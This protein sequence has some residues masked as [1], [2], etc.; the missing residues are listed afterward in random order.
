MEKPKYYL[1]DASKKPLGRIA[2]RAAFLL[3]GKNR[4]EFQPNVVAKHIIIIINAGK[5]YLSGTKNDSKQ[6]Y[7]YSGY[8]GGLKT[9]TFSELK[10]ENPVKIISHAVEG[11][12]PKNRLKSILIKN[13]KIVLTENHPY[14]K[15]EL[16]KE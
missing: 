10:R 13:L 11:M 5:V 8:H 7:R 14:T 2:T 6:Y 12:L 4:A 3:Q 9:E 1:L 15:E 16:I